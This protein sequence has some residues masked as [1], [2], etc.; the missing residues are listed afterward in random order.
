MLIRTGAA[1]LLIFSLTLVEAEA[2][3]CERD[4]F[5]KVVSEAG[6][7]LTAMNDANKRDFQAKLKALRARKGWSDE[8]YPAKAAPLVRDERMAAYDAQTQ[9][10]LAKVSELGAPAQTAALAGALPAIGGGEAQRCD[11]LAKLRALMAEVVAANR[12]KWA[13]ML[14][15]IDAELAGAPDAPAAS[16]GR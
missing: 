11:M 15:K 1:V 14:A 10:L 12:A 6:A 9:A 4:A 7:E 13:Y 5:A 8:D 2:A 3:E 16:A